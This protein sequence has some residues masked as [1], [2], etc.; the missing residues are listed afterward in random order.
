M[1]KKELKQ[2]SDELKDLILKCEEKAESIQGKLQHSSYAWYKASNALE[3]LGSA[4]AQA[5]CLT[6]DI[7]NY[8]DEMEDF[9]DV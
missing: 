3:D 8:D 7:Q 6:D 4:K 9:K 5:N 1:T 2:Q